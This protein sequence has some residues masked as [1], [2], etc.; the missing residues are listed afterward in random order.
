MGRDRRRGKRRYQ[1]GPRPGTGRPAAPEPSPVKAAAPAGTPAP[2][3][4]GTVRPIAR[5]GGP[6]KAPVLAN[7]YLGRDLRRIGIVTS[8]LV[9]LLVAL[10]LVLA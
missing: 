7:P 6:V 1:G 8:V 2:S 9:L 5:S 10:W 4:P 3:R